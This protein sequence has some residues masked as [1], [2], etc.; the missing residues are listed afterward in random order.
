[1][2]IETAKD[3]KLLYHLTKLD[4]L[5]SII[6]NR[7]VPRR[8]LLDNGM[9]FDDVANADIISKRTQLGLDIYTP[10][11]FH[12]YSSFDVAVKHANPDDEFIY[13][14]ITRHSAKH[15][16]FKILPRHPLSIE[17]CVLLDYDTGFS[18]ID[19]PVL[20]QKGLIDDYSKHVKMAECLTELAIPANFFKSIAVKSEETKQVVLE[21]LRQNGITSTPPHVNVQRYWF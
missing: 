6:V 17:E 11:H 13:I 15:N 1:M 14:C 21:I 18:Q 19:W 5:Q 7:L 4:N 8:A 9:I 3:G 2:G 20:T 12:P 10:F 16:N